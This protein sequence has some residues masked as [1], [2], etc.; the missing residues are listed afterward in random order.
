MKEMKIHSSYP[1]IEKRSGQVQEV[2]KGEKTFGQVLKESIDEVNRL[3]GVANKAIEDL[4]A[5]RTKNIHE[6]MIALE[7]AEI[8]FKLMLRVRNKI[9]EAYNEVMRMGV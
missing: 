5:G 8:S 3:Q 2:A 6:T 1:P 4:T 7:K 9:L